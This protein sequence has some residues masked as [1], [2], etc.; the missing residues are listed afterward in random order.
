MKELEQVYPVQSR[1]AFFRRA[2]K[3]SLLRLLGTPRVYG[4]MVWALSV[5]RVDYD[6]LV[7]NAAHSFRGGDFF[8]Q[9][10]RR[11]SEPLLQ[12]LA[13]RIRGFRRRG[14]AALEQRIE[15]GEQLAAALLPGAVLGAEND[16]H[17]YWVSAV[18]LENADETIAALRRAGFDATR[19]SSMVVAPAGDQPGDEPLAGWLADTVFLP[20]SEQMPA[21]EWARLLS[22]LRGVARVK[23]LDERP[24]DEALPATVIAGS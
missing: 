10:R 18:Y 8:A 17:T 3:Y 11:P 6:R 21:R 2:M 15:R 13:R 7:G 9:I 20:S 1:W 4:G 14:D 23:A 24:A 5:G 22:E 19:C 12:L 16:S